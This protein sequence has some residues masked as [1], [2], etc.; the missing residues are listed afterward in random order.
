MRIRWMWML[1]VA[2]M[3][4]PG[5]ATKNAPAQAEEPPGPRFSCALNCSGVE[6]IATGA[7]EQEA[8]AAARALVP[9]V[10]NPDDGQFFITC[11]PSA[12]SPEE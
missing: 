7:T 2:T 6:K 8:Y 5:C 12:A 9:D 4:A 1:G 3:L 10:C 11:E